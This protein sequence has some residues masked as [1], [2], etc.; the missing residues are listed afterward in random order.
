MPNKQTYKYVI[1]NSIIDANN[2]EYNLSKEEYYL[3]YSFYVTYSLCKKQSFKKRNFID[4]GWNSDSYE[5]DKDLKNTLISVLDFSNLHTFVFTENNDLKERFDEQKLND[6]IPNDYD[7]ERGVIGKT[8]E[9]NRY[10]KLFYRI[11]NCL[12]HGKFSLKLSSN[13]EKMICFQ[14]DDKNNVT[15]R[16]IIKLSTILSFIYSIDKNNILEY[17]KTKKYNKR[18]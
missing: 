8:N 17:S 15:A 11:R 18:S 1:N 13:D 4:Y 9:N 3:I 5:K 16:I 12:A 2:D 10:L 14:D 7:I 6:G